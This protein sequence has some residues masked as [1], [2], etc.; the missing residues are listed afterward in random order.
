MSAPLAR[1]LASPSQTAIDSLEG[2]LAG[3]AA[4]DGG[5]EDAAE[6]AARADRLGLAFT[7]GYAA[8]TRGLGRALGHDGWFT[9]AASESGGAHP[10]AIQTTLREDGAGLHL[11]GTKRWSTLATVAPRILVI[12]TRGARDGRPD[13]GAVW[14]EPGAPGV[15]VTRMPDAPFCPEV[16]HAE[17]LLDARVARSAAIDG[18]AYAEIVKPFRTLEDVAVQA[19]LLAFL[20]G[21]GRRWSFDRALI[22]RAAA[23]FELSLALWRA[24]VNRAAASVHDEAALHVALDGLLAQSQALIEAFSPEWQR[25][26]AEVGARVLR[27]LPLLAIAGKARVLRA[28]RAWQRIEATRETP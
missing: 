6:L 20:I 26:P 5:L 1:V 17:L 11:G 9:L 25:A 21:S 18:D 12:A 2:V 22:A 16:P 8:A 23:L 4:S 28:E 27:D 15:T 10:R 3:I 24:A 14:I 7:L 19:A 13:L